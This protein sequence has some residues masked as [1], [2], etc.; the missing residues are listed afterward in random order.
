MWTLKEQVFSAGAELG[1][2]IREMP[3]E[4][5]ER[6]VREITEKYT[7]NKLGWPSWEKYA[8]RFSVQDEEAWRWVGDYVGNEG[9]I[10]FFQPKD[11]HSAFQ[12]YSGPDLVAVLGELFGVEF[13]VTNLLTEYVL[14][15][16]HHEY[17]IAV[18]RAIEW[19]QHRSGHPNT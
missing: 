16:N 13:Y 17:L 2:E 19:L 7:H 9:A 14:C 1:I 6:L 8:E 12:F 3:R 10:L 4:E 11:E 15:F 5:Q 18:G